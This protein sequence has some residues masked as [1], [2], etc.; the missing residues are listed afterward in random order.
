MAEKKEIKGERGGGDVNMRAFSDQRSWMQTASCATIN[1]DNETSPSAPPFSAV[2]AYFVHNW[3]ST[4]LL[5]LDIFSRA[6]FLL[7]FLFSLGFVVFLS[8]EA[9]LNLTY[10][11]CLSIH[12]LAFAPL[13][14]RG[15]LI[16][17]A[18][19][20]LPLNWVLNR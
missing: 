12:T 5:P 9:H 11:V 19:N 2:L 14:S 13:A 7:I 1:R 15:Y 3:C 20:N 18:E 10:S 6:V 4:K 17:S 8:S 16:E